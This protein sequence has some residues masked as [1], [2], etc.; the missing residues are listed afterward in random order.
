VVLLSGD[1]VQETRDEL[2]RLRK[3][4]EQS[5][6]EGEDGFQDNFDRPSEEA[7][8]LFMRPTPAPSQRPSERRAPRVSRFVTHLDHIARVSTQASTGIGDLLAREP[9][10]C[11]L[12]TASA[13]T[14]AAFLLT[15]WV[16][17]T[18]ILADIKTQTKDRFVAGFARDHRVPMLEVDIKAL[19]DRNMRLTQQWYGQG[20]GNLVAF[21]QFFMQVMEVS[22]VTAFAMSVIPRVKSDDGWIQCVDTIQRG[23]AGSA[24]RTRSQSIVDKGGASQAMGESAIDNTVLNNVMSIAEAD[25]LLVGS[26]VQ[27]F[28]LTLLRLRQRVHLHKLNQRLHV[29]TLDAAS[30]TRGMGALWQNKAPPPAVLRSILHVATA[31]ELKEWGIDAECLSW[32]CLVDHSSLLA[33]Y[34]QLPA[35]TQ[36]LVSKMVTERTGAVA[37]PDADSDGDSAEVGKD[38]YCTHAALILHS[39]CTH[40]A[41]I[42]HS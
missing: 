38:A 30:G 23:K 25:R 34:G 31:A 10:V 4:L 2:K 1:E 6:A 28:L 29:H 17:F 3:E 16:P 24:L 35:A 14:R 33:D 19:A 15:Y 37:V 27:R 32:R 13:E 5:K 40:T 9:S 12:C 20:K 8:Q 42:L 41:L 21:Y 36:K 18:D 11:G 22:G 7:Q 26:L 39:Y